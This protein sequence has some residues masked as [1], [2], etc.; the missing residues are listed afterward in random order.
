MKLL[1]FLTFPIRGCFE[2]RTDFYKK[3]L[4]AGILTVADVRKMEGLES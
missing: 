2:S 1:R 4:A 3:M